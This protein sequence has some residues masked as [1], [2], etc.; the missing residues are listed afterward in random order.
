MVDGGDI[1]MGGEDMSPVWIAF[2]VGLFLG[3]MFGVFAI[4]LLMMIKKG[5]ENEDKLQ[6]KV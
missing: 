6:R 3:A 4:S 2:G 1:K 5:E